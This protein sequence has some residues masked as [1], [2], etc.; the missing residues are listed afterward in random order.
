MPG[1]M[2]CADM[3]ATPLSAD[4]TFMLQAFGH[5]QSGPALLDS[6]FPP[7]EEHGLRTG[8]QPPRRRR[9]REFQQ[10]PERGGAWHEQTD[11]S[12]FFEGNGLYFR[13]PDLLAGSGRRT[14][15]KPSRKSASPSSCWTRISCYCLKRIPPGPVALLKWRPMTRVPTPPIWAP[16]VPRSAKRIHGRYGP[17]AVR[18]L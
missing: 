3:P 8:R 11:Q 15:K 13:R 7:V 4:V 18:F 12:R 14:E 2:S 1:A 17:C 6:C 10:R 5:G 16:P 9:R